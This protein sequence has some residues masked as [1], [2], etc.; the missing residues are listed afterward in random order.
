MV[1]H[2]PAPDEV[3]I[4][5]Q[6]YGARKKFPAGINLW[7]AAKALGVDISSLCAGKGTCGKCKVKLTKGLEGLSPPGQREL[8]HIS[9]DEMK[10][11]IRLACQAKVMKS[12]IVF[13]PERSR[14]GKQR[15]QTEGMEI[16]VEPNPLVKKIFVKVTPPTLHDMRA[17]EDRLLEAL[18]ETHGLSNIKVDFE[19]VRT[20][21]IVLRKGN[22]EVTVVLW[23]DEIRGVEPGNTTERC[24]GFASDIGTTK[25]AGFLMDLN[26][27]K[28]ISLAARM[29]PQIPLGEDVMSRITHAMM[30]GWEA[31]VELQK[32]VIGGLNEIIDECCEKAKV[33]VEEIYELNFV[34][35][36]AMQLLFL[37]VWPQYAALAPYPAVVRRGMDVHANKL[38]LKSHP[39]ANTHF[40]P[41]IGGFVGADNVAV[42]LASNML[43]ADDM[44]LAIDIGT[45]TEIDLGNKNGILSDS[46]ASGPAFEGMEVR[47]G[48]RASTGAIERISIDPDSLDIFYR[49]IGDE[50]PV[51][52]CGSA[53]VD[54]PAEMFKSGIINTKGAFVPEFEKRTK[55][56]RKGPQGWEYVVAWKDETNTDTDITV[57]QADVRELQKAKAA[58]HTGAEILMRRMNVKEDDIA[59]LVIAGAFGNYVDPEN[60][61]ILGM[62][63]EIAMDR[64]KFVGNIAGTGSRM[65][66]ISEEMREYAEK[67]SKTVKY[68][69]LAVDPDFQDEYMKSFYFPHANLDRYPVTTKLLQKLGRLP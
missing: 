35:N 39:N 8:K 47:F 69:E 59:H 54:A 5:F 3:E 50:K 13:V 33:K 34:G 40:L 24:F 29:N 28:V 14:V 68:L 26:T 60:A 51:G 45:N 64:I 4:V 55:R 18:K 23:K 16:A 36:T 52:I 62:Y 25:L 1:S 21:P 6:P 63:P 56:I 58:M 7:E 61:R 9:E 17:D 57:T 41:V 27:G 38:G 10:V 30:N 49:T 67:I 44:T 42:V 43:E 66:L 37:G 20:L 65:S 15:L 11:N 19:V 2:I 46:C 12:A 53:L 32:A 31:A 48:M 22:W